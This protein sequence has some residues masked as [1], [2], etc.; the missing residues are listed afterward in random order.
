[1][2]R[3]FFDDEKIDLNRFSVSGEKYNHIIR[4]LR[5]SVGEKVVFCDGNFYDYECELVSYDTENAYFEIQK[6]YVNCTEPELR[7]TVFQCLPKGDKMDEMVKRCVQF[8]VHTIVPVLSR[9]CVSRPEHKS[10]V[11]KIE[12]L[13]KI[14]RA[15]AMQSMRGYIPQVSEIIGFEQAVEQMKGFPNSFI[16]YENEMNNYFKIPDQKNGDI[17]FLIGPEGGLDNSEVEYAVNNDVPCVSLGKRIL[18]TEDA[19]SFLIPILLYNTKNL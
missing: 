8:G 17:A 9:R 10:S 6:K 7:I 14:A 18:R 1:M 13:N 2:Q 3:F 5:I 12:R 16:C 19:A 11:K 4:S 15:S